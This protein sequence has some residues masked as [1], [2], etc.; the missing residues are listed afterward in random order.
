[1]RTFT[2]SFLAIAIAACGSATPSST[3]AGGSGTVTNAIPDGAHAADDE[4]FRG[5]A[6]DVAAQTGRQV[7]GWG[8]ARLADDGDPRRWAVLGLVDGSGAERG[9][10]LVEIAPGRTLLATFELDGRTTPWGLSDATPPTWVASDAVAIEHQQTHRGGY[11]SLR[12]ALHGDALVVLHRESLE[13]GRDGDQPTIQD[14][15]PGGVCAP[16]C[17]A[18]AGFASDAG[19]EV[20]GPGATAAELAH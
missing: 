17:P 3:G 7:S 1:M 5:L 14:Y 10:Y 8:T 2:V 6:Q 18:L 19:F 4:T 9:A 11:E 15:A 13:D 12:V 20:V 16:A